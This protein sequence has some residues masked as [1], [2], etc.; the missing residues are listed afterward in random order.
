MNLDRI[1]KK[2]ARIRRDYD[3]ACSAVRRERKSLRLARKHLKDCLTAQEIVRQI[4]QAVQQA[5]HERIAGIVSSCL[6]AIFA[7]GTTFRLVFERKRNRTEA[8]MLFERGGL[9]M[10]PRGMS[11]GSVV[12]VAALALRVANIFLAR[13]KVRM[14]VC[15]DEPLRYLSPHNLGKVG[16]MIRTLGRELGMQFVLTT[17]D[18]SRVV[19]KAVEIG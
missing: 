17:P 5:T 9:E 16:E 12:D 1:E 6:E 18:P 7:D 4:A 3:D 13:P 2:L 15:L 19:G 11:G 8:R 10:S 14:L